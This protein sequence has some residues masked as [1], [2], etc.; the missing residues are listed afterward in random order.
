M[1]RKAPIITLDEFKEKIKPLFTEDVHGETPFPYE[2]P[3]IIAKDLKK[4]IFDF[5]NWNAGDADP[6]YNPKYEG[7][8]TNGYR[9][10]SNNLPVLFCE[11]G[12]DWEDPVVFILYWDGKDVRAYIP[13]EGNTWHPKF[14]A[15]FGSWS[16]SEKWDDTCEEMD[17]NPRKLDYDLIYN[18]IIRRIEIV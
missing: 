1:S 2:L 18:D 15:A 8:S 9:V 3:E 11:A 7:D 17:E 14:K 16:S 6:G 12:G 10:L 4:V 13:K 5:E